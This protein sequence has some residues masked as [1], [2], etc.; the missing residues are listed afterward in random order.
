MSISCPFSLIL[1]PPFSG[2]SCLLLLVSW[3][4]GRIAVF[5]KKGVTGCAL[6]QMHSLTFQHFLSIRAIPDYNQESQSRTA[7]LFHEKTH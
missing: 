3:L 5:K 6:P 7:L 2:S 4:A 1:S